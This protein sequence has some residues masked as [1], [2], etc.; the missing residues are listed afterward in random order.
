[1]AVLDLEKKAKGNDNEALLKATENL[2]TAYEQLVRVFAP[3]VK[4]LENF[5]LVLYPLWHEALPKKDFKAIIACAPTLQ[6]KMDTL[7]KVD[8]PE[9]FKEN[10]P[11]FIE[12]RKALKASVEEL[13]KA[14]N[15]KDNKKI[16]EKLDK[17]HTAYMELDGVFEAK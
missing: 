13:I 3:R 2:H 14:C 12:K 11:Q 16:E 9:K 5:H 8:F 17:M 6:E 7:M 10:V 15:K 4:E 1:M